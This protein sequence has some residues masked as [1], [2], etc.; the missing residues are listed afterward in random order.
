MK[1]TCAARGRLA[2]EVVILDPPRKGCDA[3]LLDF[4]AEREVPRIVYI[5]CSPDSLARDVAHLCTLGYQ[6]DKITPVDLFPRTGH[7]ESV[8]CLVRE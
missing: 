3:A 4:L 7:V 5:S 1:P 6:P 8:V 2:P